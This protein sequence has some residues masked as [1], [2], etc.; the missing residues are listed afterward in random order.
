MPRRPAGDDR[1]EEAALAHYLGI[2]TGLDDSAKSIDLSKSSGPWPSLGDTS[3]TT[4]LDRAT[5]TTALIKARERWLKTPA[6]TEI[7]LQLDKLVR[8]QGQV[9]TVNEAAL[10]LLALRGCAMQDDAE[11]L[12]LAS[13]VLRAALEAESHLD[14]PR[15]ECFDHQPSPLIATNSAWAD[16]ARQLGNVADAC[17][18]AEPLLPPTRV[19]EALEAVKPAGLLGSDQSL[20]GGSGPIVS[21]RLLRLA[22][23]ASRQAALSSR[24][25]IYSQGMPALQALRQSLGALVGAPMLRT[26]EL[27]DRVRGRYPDATP[28][29]GHPELDRL[30]EEAGAPLQWSATA[31]QGTGAYLCASLGNGLVAGTTSMFSRQSTYLGVNADGADTA[32]LMAE[33]S[34]AEDRLQRNIKSGGLLVMTVEPRQSRHAEAELLRRFGSKSGVNPPLQRVSFDALLLKALHEEATAAKVDWNKVLSADAA[35][36]GSRDWSNLQRL[37]Q[38]TL[39]SLTPLLLA[40]TS[41]I[42]LTNVGLLARYRLMSLITEIESLTGRPGNTPSVWLLLASHKQGLPFID[43]SPVP[44]VNS[45]LAFRLPQA[46]TENKHRAAVHANL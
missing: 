7:R 35:E 10:A 45:T 21:A 13:A 15:F 11:R 37:V 34:N 42:L 12:Q 22:T 19:L 18:L 24:Q 32:A 14:Q 41:P 26:R 33:A 17:A 36:P 44:L 6:F 23:S 29:P 3:V 16:Y 40:N 8:T 39:L 25:E 27:Q 38:R 20:D 30:L 9:M 1:P 2:D 46:W 5:L 43:A 4:G 31:A 28:L